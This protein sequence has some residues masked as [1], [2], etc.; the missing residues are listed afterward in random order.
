MD[1]PCLNN[2]SD[3]N[4]LRLLR[5]REGPEIMGSCVCVCFQQ[6]YLLLN[7]THAKVLNRPKV[8]N[9]ARA[10]PIPSNKN[11]PHVLFNFSKLE[12]NYPYFQERKK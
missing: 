5:L 12:K 8:C 1:Q 10:F 2:S 11:H 6:K 3:P 7:Y 9:T 4:V